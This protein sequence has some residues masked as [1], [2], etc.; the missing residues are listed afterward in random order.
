MI[1]T[2]FMRPYAQAKTLQYLPAIVALKEAYEQNAFDAIFVGPENQLLESGSANFF[3]FEGNTLITP[4][5]DVLPGI[6]Q[7][8]VL[9]L[10]KAHFAIEMRQL[11]YDEIQSFDGA[12]LTATNKEV[13]PIVQI[14]SFKIGDGAISENIKL[15][16]QLFQ[17]YTRLSSWAT[18]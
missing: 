10:A 4:T 7:K 16:M 13:M 2:P 3:A 8:I 9:N 11:G 1:T 12:F 17:E 5:Q 18:F 6:T 15:L 14:D